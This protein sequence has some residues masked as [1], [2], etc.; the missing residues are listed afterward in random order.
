MDKGVLRTIK[1][2]RGIA[3]AVTDRLH[4]L[5]HVSEICLNLEQKVL[6]LIGHVSQLLRLLFRFLSLCGSLRRECRLGC[7][8]RSRD[9]LVG[10]LRSL[11]VLFSQIMLLL[12][13]LLELR[14]QFVHQHAA[15][16]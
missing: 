11:V 1:L 3:K 4:L 14:L 6:R 9:C 7:L 15:K 10:L 5:L 2:R 16:G 13:Q 12:R 8:F